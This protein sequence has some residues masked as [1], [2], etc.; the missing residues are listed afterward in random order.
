[1]AGSYKELRPWKQSVELAIKIYRVP[2]TLPR[3]ELYGLSTQMRRAAV[4]VASN[5]AEGKGR[6]TDKEFALFLY[7]AR[8][9]LLEL[10]TQIVIARELGYLQAVDDLDA[11]T[12]LL[13][14]TINA[15]LNVVRG[16]PATR[17]EIIRKEVLSNSKQAEP[18]NGD[19][20]S[21]V[22]ATS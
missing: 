2:Q 21:K 16:D 8:G 22:L 11:K 9:S 4:S 17:P 13:A 18:S 6:S 12:E 20:K 7:H 3:T 14:K 19:V 5:F 1:M 10:E 15:L